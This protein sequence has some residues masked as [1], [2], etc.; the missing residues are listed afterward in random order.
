MYVRVRMQ[1]SCR[2]GGT[3]SHRLF[4]GCRPGSPRS[5]TAGSYAILR[6]TCFWAV[7]GTAASAADDVAAS[8]HIVGLSRLLEAE[9][10]FVFLIGNVMLSV[11]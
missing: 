3:E 4:P 8:W 6:A 10:M 11:V 1:R 2:N 7:L 9:A 5:P